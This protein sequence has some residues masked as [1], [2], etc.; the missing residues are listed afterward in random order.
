MGALP[1]NSDYSPSSHHQTILQQAIGTNSVGDSLV[2]SYGRSLNG[3]AAKLTEAER[4]KLGGKKGVVSVFESR[5]LKLLTT[6]SWDFMGFGGTFKHNPKTESDMVIG[7]IDSGIWPE[8]PSF[9]DKGFGPPPKNWKGVCQGGSNFTCNNK[10]IGARHYIDDTARDI[11][12][13]GTH[14][15]STAA[16]NE[17]EGVSFHGLAQGTARGGVP[18]ARIA[19]YKACKFIFCSD[20][21][22]LAAF[23]D[24]IADGVDVITISLGA[25]A[26]P[27]DQNAISIGSFHAMERGILTVNACGNDG[28]SPSSI[29]SVAPWM[30]S[31]AASTTDRKFVTKVVL[32]NGTALLGGS[33]I[34]SFEMNGTKLALV[35]GKTATSSCSEEEARKCD[36]NCFGEAKGKILVCDIAID[37]GLAAEAGAV[38]LIMNAELRNPK[39]SSNISIS[40][41]KNDDYKALLS[42]INSTENPQ[43]SILKS[44]TI[45]DTD[46]PLVA[47]FSSRG[48]NPIVSDIL[49]PDIT[50]PGVNII[51][52]Y[53][54]EVEQKLEYYF[55]T[56]T[57]MSC[58]HIAGVAAYVKTVHPDWSASAIKSAIMTTAWAMN[59]S[60]NEGAEFA[61]GSGH[62]N[63]TKAADP[64]LVYDAT[65]DDYVKMLCAMNYTTESVRIIAGNNSS[66]PKESNSNVGDLNY[67]SMTSKVTASSPSE[68]VFPRTVTNVGTPDSTY[69]AEVTSNPKLKVTVE[70]ESLVFGSAGEKKSFNVT[71]AHEDLSGVKGPVSA[72]LV[73]S[74][75]SHVVRSPIVLYS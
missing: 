56:G 34:N 52:A 60:R 45:K 30:L 28:P 69:K 15:A 75:G 49:K 6:G 25:R 46:A 3:F 29:A 65:K 33:V 12:G 59:G 2:R 67:P 44:E 55:S 31:V 19:V 22:I 16:G 4:D 66:C 54:P 70:P 20:E 39:V 8:S 21:G 64:G 10:I 62:L 13:H 42:Y 1:P 9:T 38:G 50:A 41:L 71:V 51:A 26:V 68:I 36:L 74:D 37:A 43:G 63:P 48:P 35:Y 17:V 23:D 40:A 72:S 61:Y 18:S 24:A 58:P 73:W 11:Q 32:G 27:L 7:V 57:S 5:D 53:S 47:S 14:T